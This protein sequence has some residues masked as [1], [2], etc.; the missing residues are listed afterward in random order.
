LPGTFDLDLDPGR[1][2]GRIRWAKE[3]PDAGIQ[4]LIDAHTQPACGAIQN[5]AAQ[6]GFLGACQA[7]QDSDRTAFATVRGALFTGA[8]VDKGVR[9]RWCVPRR[10][11]IRCGKPIRLGILVGSVGPMPHVAGPGNPRLPEKVDGHRNKEANPTADDGRKPNLHGQRGGA[12]GAEEWCTH[13]GRVKGA[14]DRQR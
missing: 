11:G 8:P 12:S 6:L 9:V 13:H 5:L 7:D 14:G 10:V 3:Q 1:D 4:G 2:W